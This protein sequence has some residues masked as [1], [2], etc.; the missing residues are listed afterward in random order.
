MKDSKT[1]IFDVKG[2]L[3]NQNIINMTIIQQNWISSRWKFRNC[4]FLH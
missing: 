2:V 1:V 3:K 4:S